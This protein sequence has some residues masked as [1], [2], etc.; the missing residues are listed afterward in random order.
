MG[1]GGGG[2]SAGY[3]FALFLVYPV[4]MPDNSI[5]YVDRFLKKVNVLLIFNFKWNNV[6]KNHVRV[7]KIVLKSE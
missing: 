1:G 6:L 7:K 5:D 2:W 4:D 3:N